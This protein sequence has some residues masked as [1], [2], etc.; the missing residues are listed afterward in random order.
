MGHTVEGGEARPQLDLLVADQRRGV[1]GDVGV[2][3]GPGRGE[4]QGLTR[5]GRT[6]IAR[7]EGR[8]DLVPGPHRAHRDPVGDGLRHG[9]D[10]GPDSRV[11]EAEPGAGPGESGLDLVEDQQDPA[12]VAQL[13]H[14]PQVVVGGRV[15]PSLALDRLEKDRTHLGTEGPLELVEI[16]PRDVAEPLRQR[17]EGLVL[18]RLSGCRQRGQRAAVE[19]TQRTHHAV[20]APTLVLPGQLDGRLVGLRTRV[21][22]EHLPVTQVEEFADPLGHRGLVLVGEEVGGVGEHPRLRADG[23]GD[24]RMS[25]AECGDREPTQ[26]IEMA[27]TLPVPQFRAGTLHEQAGW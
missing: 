14:P 4:G 8:G 27:A 7:P 3:R 23:L 25:V 24:G 16:V 10:V 5:V 15:D 11:L 26:E 17:L 9:D 20:T 1:D 19:R 6:V 22:E 13:P 12:L 18:L 2:E 21:L